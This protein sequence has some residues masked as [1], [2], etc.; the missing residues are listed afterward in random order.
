MSEPAP[1]V[2]PKM[3]SRWIEARRTEGRRRLRYL[4]GFGIAVAIGLL[5]WGSLYTPLL[6]L[7]HVVVRGNK[8]L[9]ADEVA[10]S[11]GVKKGTP[12]IRIK[13]EQIERDLRR[14][15]WVQTAQVSR[16]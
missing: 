11:G 10:K 9:S 3:K 8:A 5:A 14:N 6:N 12:L 13:S 4:I 16:S 15:P 7:D 1:K 2:H